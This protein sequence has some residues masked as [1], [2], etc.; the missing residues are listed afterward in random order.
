VPTARRPTNGR[1]VGTDS[2]PAAVRSVVLRLAII[3]E[4]SK[5]GGR[6]GRS[7]DRNL[8]RPKSLVL[9]NGGQTRGT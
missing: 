1:D 2:R 9:S 5:V 4:S 3:G 8:R 6:L 7:A